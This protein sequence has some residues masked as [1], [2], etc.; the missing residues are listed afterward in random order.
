[1]KITGIIRR[2]DDLGRVVIPKEIRRQ[3]LVSQWK[4]LLTEKILYSE[5]MRK[6]KHVN[7]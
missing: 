6:Y 5:D 7:G 2:V 3:V 1:M 4:Y